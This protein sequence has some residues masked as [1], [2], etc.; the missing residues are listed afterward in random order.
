MG[1]WNIVMKEVG[2]LKCVGTEGFRGRKLVYLLPVVDLSDWVPELNGKLSADGFRLEQR[3]SGQEFEISGCAEPARATCRPSCTPPA[4]PG[5]T[6]GLPA[7]SR[8]GSA[9]AAATPMPPK[10]QGHSTGFPPL[11]PENG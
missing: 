6:S 2:R 3:P 5:Q 10:T 11:P 8:W 7:G 9:S 4:Y 1:E